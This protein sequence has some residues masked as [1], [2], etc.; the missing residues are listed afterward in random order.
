MFGNYVILS[1]RPNPCL[2]AGPA[3]MRPVS[4]PTTQCGRARLAGGERHTAEVPGPA[5]GWEGSAAGRAE[6]V[7]EYDA[8]QVVVE[9][10]ARWVVVEYDANSRHMKGNASCCGRIVRVAPAVRPG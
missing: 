9:Y 10:D 6:V 8:R 4:S 2:R 7:V 1:G 5:G 3:L